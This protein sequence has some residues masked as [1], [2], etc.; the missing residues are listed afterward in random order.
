MSE[1]WPVVELTPELARA[2]L[3]NATQEYVNMAKAHRFAHDIRD[4]NWFTSV[5]TI[6]TL[7][8]GGVRLGNGHHRCH[9]VILA[10]RSIPV[11]VRRI[12][13]EFNHADE[14][15]E[16][17]ALVAAEAARNWAESSREPSSAPKCTWPGC[18]CIDPPC[19]SFWDR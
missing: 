1:D 8:R 19:Q 4:G 9:A 2:W 12:D 14:A 17:A 15:R 10:D 6:I 3:V 16:V 18:Q 7:S 13:G 5:P 11:R